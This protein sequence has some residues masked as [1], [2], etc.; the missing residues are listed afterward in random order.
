LANAHAHEQNDIDRRND[1][2]AEMMSLLKMQYETK[3]CITCNATTQAGRLR[4]Q[5]S[6]DWWK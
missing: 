4:C 6:P 3:L 2:T 5:D 1:L